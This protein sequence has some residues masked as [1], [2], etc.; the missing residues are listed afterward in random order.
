VF[1]LAQPWPAPRACAGFKHKAFGDHIMRDIFTALLADQV[2]SD[3]PEVSM[4]LDGLKRQLDPISLMFGETWNRCPIDLRRELAAGEPFEHGYQLSSYGDPEFRRFLKSFLIE[5]EAWLKPPSLFDISS[6]PLEVAAVWSGTRS[7]LFDFARF[8]NDCDTASSTGRP[9]ALCASPSWDYR[10]I[11]EGLGITVQYILLD[12]KEAFEITPRVIGDA[13]QELKRRN[14][15]V[16]CV[17]LNPQHNP[18]GKN[19][20]VAE[21]NWLIDLA[22]QNHS[23]IIVDNAYFGMTSPAQQSTSAVQVLLSRWDELQEAGL[24]DQILC[25]RSLGKIFHCSGWGIGAMAATPNTLATLVNR[26]RFE[27]SYSIHGFLQRAMLRWMK[28]EKSTTFVTAL[29][30]EHTIKRA[31]ISSCFVKELGYPPD[32]IHVGTHTPYALWQLP[33]GFMERP[34]PVES[35]I[36][37]TFHRSGVL[38]MKCHGAGT[39]PESRDVFPY[40]RAY[41][42]GDTETLRRALLRIAEARLSWPAVPE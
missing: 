5:T 15:R 18:T 12:P 29:H 28:S 24:A 37:D 14:G 10:S 33:P 32:A 6:L 34:Q 31:L 30:H 41:L 1:Q 2:V 23:A 17:I 20:S 4:I 3:A 38:L 40:V 36:K 13:V 27:R 22:I 9:Y 19:W 26:Y 21:I 8:L 25:V 7:V 42:G 35:Y 39:L 16:R 11:L